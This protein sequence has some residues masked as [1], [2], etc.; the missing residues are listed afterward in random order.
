MEIN[1]YQKAALRTAAGYMKP[2][3]ASYTYDNI[4][5]LL[6]GALGLAGET[7]EVVDQL[8]KYLYQGHPLNQKAIAEE[9][10]DVCWYIAVMA[11]GLG[12]SFEDI[13]QGNIDKLKKRYPEGFT[14]EKSL[15][16]N[17]KNEK[18]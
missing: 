12:L 17:V 1:D 18:T 2:N 8:K 6:N 10:G 11:E 9:L 13:L 3:Q 14:T 15:G 4:D 7:G 5:Y 16:R